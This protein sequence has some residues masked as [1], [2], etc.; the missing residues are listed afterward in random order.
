MDFLDINPS[1][2]R[3]TDTFGWTDWHGK[4]KRCC[5]QL[6]LM[7]LET[8]VTWMQGTKKK[9]CNLWYDQCRP[10]SKDLFPSEECPLSSGVLLSLVKWCIYSLS[11]YLMVLLE[12]QRLQHIAS[13][14]DN[15]P[16]ESFGGLVIYR[17]HILYTGFTY[18]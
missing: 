15:N 1:C 16:D 10:I 11:A 14:L 9:N 17:C 6:M 5:L 3:W 2:G 8:D 18:M 7:F 12:Q 4:A 13:W